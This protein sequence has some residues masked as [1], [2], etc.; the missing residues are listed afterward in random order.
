MLRGWRR[1]EGTKI[2][3]GRPKKK[4]PSCCAIRAFLI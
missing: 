2:N 1:R 3:G 4:R